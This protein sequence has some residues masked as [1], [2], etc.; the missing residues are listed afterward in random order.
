LVREGATIGAGCIIGNDLTIGRW[1]MIGMGSLVTKSIPDFMLAM[2]HPAQPVGVI[3]RCGQLMRRFEPKNFPDE[4]GIVCT[5]C[6]RSYDLVGG[7]V[8]ERDA[9]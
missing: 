4:R 2:G 9:G 6:A 8:T 7:T 1:A 3:C 5:H